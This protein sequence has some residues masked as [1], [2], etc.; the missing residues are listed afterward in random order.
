MI[1]ILDI[2]ESPVLDNRIT[3]I[4]IH[5]YNPYANTNL[6][7][8][9]EIRIPIQHQDLYILPSQS[10]LYIEGKVTR[11]DE[12]KDEIYLDNNCMAFLFDEIRYE[13]D[14]VEIDQCRNV[15]ITTSIKNYL[16]VGSI[17]KNYVENA[18]WCHDALKYTTSDKKLFFNFCVPL[19]MLL[20]FCEDYNH[21]VINARQELILIRSRNDLNS[22]FSGYDNT[23]VNAS[24]ELT[25]IQWKIPHITLEE[26][27]KLAILR[28]VENGN[29]V[30]MNCRTW[31]LYEYPLLQSSTK[32][33]WAVKAST[34]L[35]KPR[36]IILALQTNRKDQISNQSHI[37]DHCNIS[38][39]RLYL[40]SESYPYD[41]LN[42]DF[43]KNNYSLLYLMYSKFKSAYYGLQEDNLLTLNKFKNIAPL[44]VIDC[45]R[46]VESIKNGT[47]DIR[48]DFEC[49]KDIP[50][51]TSAY[52]LILH[53]RIVEYSPLTN[54]VRKIT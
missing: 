7:N 38:N 52:C 15:G 16:S 32:H 36:F 1:D 2:Q 4:E 47:V 10:F 27:N 51:N 28:F 31:D 17:N 13:L 44:I 8:N 18:G 45:S 12:G 14:G 50:L 48:I 9:D 6:R 29:V 49:K 21:I 39:V 3:K 43:D 22:L 33:T 26:M 20:G 40:N 23:K 19:R 24:I 46:Q 25:K 42:I 35:E 41:N 54:I 34:Q 53:D 37:F 11:T 30:T 5:G